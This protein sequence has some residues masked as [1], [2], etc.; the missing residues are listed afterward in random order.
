M[1]RLTP[2]AERPS[3]SWL[4]QNFACVPFALDWWILV[5]FRLVRAPIMW[6]PVQ[7][8]ENSDPEELVFDGLR[9]LQKSGI[10]R[11]ALANANALKQTKTPTRTRQSSPNS[12]KKLDVALRELQQLRARLEA[13]EI[14]EARQAA[15]V[16]VMANTAHQIWAAQ[17]IQAG[18][19]GMVARVWCASLRMERRERAAV[20]VQA[21][22]S[23]YYARAQ[24]RHRREAT[25]RRDNAA[26]VI[27]AGLN[28][29]QVRRTM[30]RRQQQQPLEVARI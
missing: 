11:S 12:A 16:M 3:L 18:F 2:R 30:R 10:T 17:R 21:G 19:H 23:G 25:M 20:V 9:L 6:H 8:T 22:F 14:D 4:F 5:D 29:Q 24:A 7:S 28:G 1:R 15:R 26:R 13:A 27:Q